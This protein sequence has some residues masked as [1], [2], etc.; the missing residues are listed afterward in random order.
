MAKVFDYKLLIMLGLS[1]VVYFLYR[2]IEQLNK[3][4]AE[5]EKSSGNLKINKTP[6]KILAPPE[7]EQKTPQKETTN[8]KTPE[9]NDGITVEEY[10]NHDDNIYS[11]DKLDTN[12]NENDTV[13]IESITNM[14]QQVEQPVK[15]V[16]ELV[17][18]VEQHEQVIEPVIEPIIEQI[19][20]PVEPVIEQEKTGE[21]EEQNDLIIIT[22]VEMLCKKK[23]DEL[24]ELAK[25]YDLNINTDSGK[26]KKKADLAN[27]I[28]AKIKY[29]G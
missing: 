29:L 7:P 6:P 3:R 21:I 22:S 13:M 12:T 19:E 1:V 20:Q 26:K 17:E 14:T 10:S 23:L 18:P 11:H 15:Q 9:I 8:E 5:I 4:L 2:E 25:K 16:I 24:Y 27:E 28:F